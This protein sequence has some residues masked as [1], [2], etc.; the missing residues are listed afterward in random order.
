MEAIKMKMASAT[1][2]KNHFGQYLE[3]S[4]SEPVVV[5]RTGRAVAVILSIR[6]YE[7]LSTLEDQYWAQRA[8]QSEKR[9]YLGTKATMQFLRSK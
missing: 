7:R 8:A 5:E 4:I 1:E 2:I 6:D 9:G 3:T